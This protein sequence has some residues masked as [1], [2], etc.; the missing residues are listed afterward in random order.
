MSSTW[1][2]GWLTYTQPVS[3]LTRRYSGCSPDM[4][5]VMAALVPKSSSWAATRKK[6]VPIIVS[7]RRKSGTEEKGARRIFKAV[8]IEKCAG[9]ST[10]L[11][12]TLSQ[13]SR[14]SEIKNCNTLLLKTA[15]ED[16]TGGWG[17]GVPVRIN[18]RPDGHVKA[19]WIMPLEV[20]GEL[21]DWWC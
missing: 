14:L 7:S 6:L 19:A 18:R 2:M 1:E 11:V 8:R 21:P 20:R 17:G 3:G 13:L 5:Y 4:E 15:T 9:L 16:R 10:V 12:P